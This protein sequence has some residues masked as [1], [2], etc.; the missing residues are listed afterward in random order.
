[1]SE[2]KWPVNEWIHVV[3]TAMERVMWEG[4]GPQERRSREKGDLL[5]QFIRS[6]YTY[7]DVP[8][9][10]FEELC[11]SPSQGSYFNKYIRNDYIGHLSG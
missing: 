3:S 9:W 2:S 8:F 4:A 1:M 7:V 10:V 5:I 6:E 11:E